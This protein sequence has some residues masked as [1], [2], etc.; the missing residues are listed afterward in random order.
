ML[1]VLG[2]CALYQGCRHPS[3]EIWK[4]HWIVEDLIGSRESNILF[5]FL[6]MFL[7]RG[8]QGDAEIEVIDVRYYLLNNEERS[9]GDNP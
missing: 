2:P 4:G 1:M 7:A 9:G 5:L 3:R 6:S 8:E